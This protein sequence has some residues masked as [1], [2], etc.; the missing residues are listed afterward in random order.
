MKIPFVENVGI[1]TTKSDAIVLADAQSIH[2]HIGTIHAGAL[3]TLAETQSGYALKDIFQDHFD[4]TIMP[5]L[6]G[7]EVKYRLPAQGDIVAQA[8]VADEEQE[9]FLAQFSKR[10]RGI[11]SVAVT[12]KNS[13]KKIVFEGKFSW[14]IQRRTD[15]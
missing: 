7:A 5:L 6:R 1:D 4:E 12:L 14:F 8:S 11:I 13:E 3:Y 15:H 10:G 2:N 9:K